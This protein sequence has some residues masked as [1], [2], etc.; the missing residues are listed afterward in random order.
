MDTESSVPDIESPNGLESLSGGQLRSTKSTRS[1]SLDSSA[2]S[3]TL[4]CVA[5]YCVAD[6]GDRLSGTTGID[7]DGCPYRAVTLWFHRICSR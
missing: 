4:I 1:Q 2:P 3:D 5:E 7:G 6:S